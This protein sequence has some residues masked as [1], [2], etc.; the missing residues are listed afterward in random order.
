MGGAAGLGQG[1]PRGKNISLGGKRPG[2]TPQSTRKAGLGAGAPFSVLAGLSVIQHF[3]RTGR[4]GPLRF[5]MSARL[6]DSTTAMWTVEPR[7]PL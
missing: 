4:T 1:S 6:L 3:P 5:Q 7:R 2:L